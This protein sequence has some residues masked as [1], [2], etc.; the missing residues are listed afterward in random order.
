M[1]LRT[2]TTGVFGLNRRNRDLVLRNNPPAAISLANDKIATKRV[3]AAAG[4]PVPA[5]IADLSSHRQV[6]SLYPLLMR[7]EKGFVVKPSHGSQGKGI[8]L[9][10]YA[11]EDRVLPLH[12]PPWSLKDFVYYM[13]R[14]LAGEYA[15]GHPVDDVLIEEKINPEP[16]WILEDLPGPPDLRILVYRGDPILSMARLPTIASEGRANLHAGGV[17]LGIDLKTG[18]STHAILKEKPI[19]HHPD[20][21]LELIGREVSGF[22]ECLQLAAKCAAAAPLGYMGV[23]I[24]RDRVKGPVVIEINAHPGLA[25][26]LANRKSLDEA[27]REHSA[28]RRVS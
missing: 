3:L 11:L 10:T 16:D 18:R 24:I 2:M 22:E 27:L 13:C 28:R 5:T 21:G 9:F 4:L 14:I 1:I 23:D 15:M 20:S 25:I 8:T 17:G 12:G 6:R 26:Q 19:L 7:V